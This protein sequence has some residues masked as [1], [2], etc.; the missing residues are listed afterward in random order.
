MAGKSLDRPGAG[1]VFIGLGILIAMAVLVANVSV[2]PAWKIAT[3]LLAG[4]ALGI[5]FLRFPSSWA[6]VTPVVFVLFFGFMFTLSRELGVAWFGGY[7]AG[8]NLGSGWRIAREHGRRAA[9]KSA[10]TVDEREFGTVAAAR[11]AADTALRNLDGGKAHGRLDVEHGFA[12]F[13]VLG[14]VKTGL[15]C[16][17]NRDVSNE[18]SW[19]VLT[20]V[21]YGLDDWADVPAGR[22]TSSV[23]VRL[24]NDLGSVQRALDDFFRN[25][26]AAPEGPPWAIDEESQGTRLSRS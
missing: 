18:D 17:W 7:L 1:R 19:A 15:L 12:S 11:D 25:P 4:L 24:I 9:M 22:Y 20:R 21:G 14:D 8:T 13:Q 26:D 2:E 3:T 10:W 6:W 23:P 5:C 16:H